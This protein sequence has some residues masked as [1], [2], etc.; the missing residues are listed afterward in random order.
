MHPVG[1]TMLRYL[2]VCS[3]LFACSEQ[4]PVESMSTDETSIRDVRMRSNQ[5]IADHDTLAVAT[6][7]TE[8][9]LVISS[10]NSLAVGKEEN[11]KLFVSIFS[12][13]PDVI[14]IRKTQKI[15]V[16]EEWGMASEEGTW[17]GRWTDGADKIEIEGTYYAK[18][19]K[20]EGQWLIRT[21]VFSPT[22]CKGGSYCNNQP[23]LTP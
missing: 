23:Q 12:A 20:I 19:H 16:M 3:V 8:D 6:A 13:R 17:E 4:K 7:W 21:E 14:Y 10:T 1:N 2:F 15:D 18:W 9:F 5:A 11:R 22:Q